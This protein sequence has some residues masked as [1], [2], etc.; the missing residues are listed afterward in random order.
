LDDLARWARQNTPKDAVF[1]FA[2]AGRDLAPGVFRARATRAL[3]VDWKAGGQVNFQKHF[4]DVWWQRWQKV[5]KPQTLDRYREL[6]IDYVVFNAGGG[7]PTGAEAVY[8][9]ARYV[10]FKLT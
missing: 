8:S 10:V 5:E 1:Q 3:Y 6:G 9:N 4:S 2:E 7:V